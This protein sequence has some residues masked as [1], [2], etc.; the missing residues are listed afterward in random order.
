VRWSFKAFGSPRFLFLREWFSSVSDGKMAPEG[1]TNGE[2]MGE[3][4]DRAPFAFSSPEGGTGGVLMALE[5]GN[6]GGFD[7]LE[8]E[9]G[10]G[11]SG[12][13]SG[14]K[15]YGIGVLGQK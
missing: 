10:E 1:E 4:G 8:V 15:P 5:P 6:G 9:E 7:Y 14:R 11:S 12:P 3:E 2:R 13:E